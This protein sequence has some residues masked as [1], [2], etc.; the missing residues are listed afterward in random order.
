MGRLKLPGH[1]SLLV[2]VCCTE[3][4]SMQPQMPC[5]PIVARYCWRSPLLQLV[6]QH[7]TPHRCD[8]SSLGTTHLCSLQALNLC[9]LQ[10]PKTLASTPQVRGYLPPGIRN[11]DTQ[12]QQL[13]KPPG[14]R[15][16]SQQ[17]QT[18]GCTPLGVCRAHHGTHLMRVLELGLPLQSEESTV[19]SVLLPP[20]YGRRP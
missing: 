4:I 11:R 9:S 16:H 13:D 6:H 2:Y 3:Q 17:T 8:I 5:L 18:N 14:E 7:Y 15:P 12:L 19:T 20:L 10:A 1:C